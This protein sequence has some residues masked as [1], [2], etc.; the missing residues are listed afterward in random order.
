M[1]TVK[2]IIEAFDLEILVPGT[3]DHLIQV[4]DVNRPGLQLAGFY[5]YFDNKRIRSLATVNG[6]FG[7]WI[8]P[9]GKNGFKDI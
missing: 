7:G 9:C 6:A 8:P 2:K 1:V 3:E 4:Q 5:N